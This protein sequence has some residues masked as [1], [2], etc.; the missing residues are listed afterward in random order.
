[1][2]IFNPIILSSTFVLIS[3][4][5]TNE[6]ETAGWGIKSAAYTS[7]TV[8]VC[9]ENRSQADLE[10]KPLRSKYSQF[11]RS[12][13][14]KTRLSLVGWNDCGNPINKNEI[15][16]T[17]WDVGET[18][19][20][21]FG[22]SNIGRG[23]NIPGYTSD[24]FK[25]PQRVPSGVKAAPTLAI[26]AH[27]LI[28]KAKQIGDDAAINTLA[29]TLL[30][31][32]GHGVGLLHEHA[33]PN[34][35][36]NACN[37]GESF[38]LHKSL[39][40]SVD[41]LQGLYENAVGTKNYDPTSIMNYCYILNKE[42][43][44]VP[45]SSGDVATINLLYTNGGVP[46]PPKVSQPPRLQPQLRRQQPSQPAPVF[47]AVAPAG[48][49]QSAAAVDDWLP[50]LVFANGQPVFVCEDVMKLGYA[51]VI[52][53]KNS[54]DSKSCMVTTYEYIRGQFVKNRYL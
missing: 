14:S 24:F 42:G 33:H 41:A 23:I 16:I 13:F 19:P 48:A 35:P 53:C 4:G 6:S 17:W 26:N 50:Q 45:L 15:R 27:T 7:N 11:V 18:E 37:L 44:L 52:V 40:A 51:P 9:W 10:L 31:E 38:E 22:K 43:R 5:R 54:F 36:Q 49:C 34:K 32:I 25:L 39:W 20:T 8:N 21:L 3:C 1:M 46:P 12:E 2:K 29:S 47:S 30:H 28:N